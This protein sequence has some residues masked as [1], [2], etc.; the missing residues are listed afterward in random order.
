[1]PKKRGGLETS[2]FCRRV[3]VQCDVK[4]AT[5]RTYL[6]FIDL[7]PDHT[8]SDDG[9]VHNFYTREQIKIAVTQIK[10]LA[11]KKKGTK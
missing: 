7:Q 10:N 8:T 6:R 11:R 4:A 2:E 5:A 9:R 3:A 1:M